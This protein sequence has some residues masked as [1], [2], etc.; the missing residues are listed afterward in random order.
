[1][2]W[3]Q[4][5]EKLKNLE[6]RYSEKKKKIEYAFRTECKRKNITGLVSAQNLWNKKYYPKIK[7]LAEE[8]S[9]KAIELCKKYKAS[10]NQS[11]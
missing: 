3:T 1:M 7:A 4:L 6:K 9:N 11:K 5:I 2:T 10:I 8:Q